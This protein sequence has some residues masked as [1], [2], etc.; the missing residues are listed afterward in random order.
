MIGASGIGTYLSE[1]LPRLIAARPELAFNLLGPAPVLGELPWTRAGNV[2]IIDLDVPIYSVQEQVALFRSIPRG[3]DLFWS[4]HYNIPLAWRGRLMVTIH[5]LAHVA[6]PQFVAGPHRRAYARFMFRR[7]S[8]TADAIMTDS[9]FTRSEFRRL[10]GIRRAEPEVVHLGVDGGWLAIPPSPT[11]H[12]RP[13][14]VYVGNVKPHKNLGRLLEA[15]GQLSSSVH[16]DLLILGK[17]EGFLTGDDSVRTAAAQLAPRVR[18]LGS[19]PQ[20]LLKQYVSHAVALVLPS[21]YEGFGLPPLE[22]MACGCPAIVS[23]VASLPE[24]CGDAAAYF[25]PLEPASIAEAIL[26]VLE[27]PGLREALRCRGLEHARHFTW[28]RSAL[29]TMRVLDRVLAAA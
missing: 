12:P 20:Q 21:L 6:M 24:V 4:P 28:E 11:P 23:S 18:M 5:D 7:V 26:R 25:N 10:I 17:E 8:R 14:L 3:T 19:L 27:E 2:G 9:E 29:G 15:F 13:Y 16:C 22:A 1:L